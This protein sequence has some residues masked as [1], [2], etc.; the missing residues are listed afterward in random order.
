MKIKTSVKA[1]DKATPVLETQKGAI[2]LRDSGLKLKS[3]LKAG[4]PSKYKGQ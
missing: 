3:G 2:L 4:G 1:V